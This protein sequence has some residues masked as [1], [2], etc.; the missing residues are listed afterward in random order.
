HVVMLAYP[1]VQILDVTGPLEVFSR[2]ARWMQDHGL[3]RDLA[4]RVEVV[5]PRAGAFATSSGV[6]L[7]A[8]R[9]YREVTRADTLLVA[10]GRGCAAARGEN[11]DERAQFRPALRRRGGPRARPLCQADPPHCRTTEARADGSPAAADRQAL[12][13]RDSGEPA[14]QLHRLGR[15]DAGGVPRPL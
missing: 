8:E 3:R 10:G 7:V 11:R 2:A 12:R 15:S 9:A 5:A 13:I 14:P 1:D 4:Y 6:H